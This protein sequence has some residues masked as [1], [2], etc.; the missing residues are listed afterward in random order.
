MA[1]VPTL[2]LG[3]AGAARSMMFEERVI[4]GLRLRIDRTLCV[5]FETC[6]DFAPQVFR[7]GQ[8]GVITFV[9]E[10]ADVDRERLV[11]A[12]KSCPV[13]ALSLFDANGVDL[14]QHT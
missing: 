10:A 3:R 11:E 8:D 2:W 5:A 12:C 6:V 13:D 9:D 1:L 7:L 14:L 4:A